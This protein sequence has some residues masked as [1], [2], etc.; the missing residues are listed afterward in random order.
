MH[1]RTLI[2]KY[3]LAGLKEKLDLGGRVFYNRPSEVIVKREAPCALLFVPS[4]KKDL[5][6]G[7]KYIGDSYVRSMRLEVTICEQMKDKEGVEGLQERLDDHTKMIEDYFKNDNFFA[8]QLAAYDPDQWKFEFDERGLGLIAGLGFD[9]LQ[10]EI[11]SENESHFGAQQTSVVLHY[12]DDGFVTD[13]KYPYWKGYLA[14]I[15]KYGYDESTV[16][17]VLIEAEGDFNNG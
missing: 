13:K 3:A 10:T 4:E 12:Q 8:K 7:D 6:T 5:E 15:M 11:F 1:Y 2:W 17:P 9:D 14:K 16:D